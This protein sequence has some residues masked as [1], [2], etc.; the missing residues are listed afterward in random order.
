MSKN[1]RLLE[2]EIK[3]MILNHLKDTQ[4]LDKQTTIINELTVDGYSRRVDL[5]TVNQK[6]MIAYEVKS[7]AD[8]LHR[9]DGQTKK[10]LEY[11]DKVVIVAAKKHIDKIMNIV[12]KNVAVWEISTEGV[13]IRQRG[14]MNSS[15][16]KSKIIDLMKVN[17]LIK[18]SNQFNLIL[19]SK[20]RR[21][22]ATALNV[23][24][25]STL[26]NA[27]LYYI[28]ERFSFSNSLF[29]KHFSSNK[30]LP[31]HIKLLSPYKET[32]E[33]QKTEKEEVQSFWMNWSTSQIEDPH[34]VEISREQGKPVFGAPPAH[35]ERLLAA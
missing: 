23:L 9:L 22:A 34:L 20:N 31:R 8:S 30:A 11:F 32:R 14:K 28:Q 26:K 7:E 25:L 12:P 1:Q 19:S 29:W 3:A 15:I 21:S 2:P 5:V 16:V 18:L 17:E 4:R 24:P 13:K 6:R 33:I 10:Y 35:I 27:A